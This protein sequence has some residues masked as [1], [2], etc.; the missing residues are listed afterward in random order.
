MEDDNVEAF[1]KINGSLV[2]KRCSY[3]SIKKVTNSF[4]DELRKG[5]YGDVY[6]GE[7]LD[8]RLVTVKLLNERKDSSGEEF[9]NEVISISRTSYVNIASLVGYC[10]KGRKRALIYK[11]MPKWIS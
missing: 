11:Y 5:G 9:I 4:Q 2:P 7:L 6:K 10:F 1:L 8:G 3:S